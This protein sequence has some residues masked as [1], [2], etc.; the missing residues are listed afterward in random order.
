MVLAP[1][2]MANFV[3]TRGS[4]RL[5]AGIDWGADSNSSY[6]ILTICAYISGKF[7]LLFAHRFS[8]PEAE[9]KVQSTEG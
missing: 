1:E 9:P 7:T 5:Y 3:K 6:T 4:H 8:G 2:D